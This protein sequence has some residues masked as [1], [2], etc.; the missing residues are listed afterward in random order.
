MTA[1]AALN[2]LPGSDPTAATPRPAAPT[3]RNSRRLNFPRV[4]CL[5][6]HYLLLK[7]ALVSLPPILPA[8]RIRETPP[9]FLIPPNG[10]LLLTDTYLLHLTVPF[11]R[12]RSQG[13]IKPRR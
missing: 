11:T 7:P 12:V 8:C 3:F 5:S 1:G 10:S 4:F 6:I 9:P 2:A 13:Q